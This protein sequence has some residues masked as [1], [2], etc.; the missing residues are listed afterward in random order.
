MNE[1]VVNEW[2]NVSYLTFF[3]RSNYHTSRHLTSVLPV[4]H[5][6]IYCVRQCSILVLGACSIFSS[7]FDCFL[8]CKNNTRFELSWLDSAVKDYAWRV[9]EFVC[10]ARARAGILTLA[11]SL[12][13]TLKAKKQLCWNQQ[14]VNKTSLQSLTIQTHENAWSR[15]NF[16]F[17]NQE[18]LFWIEEIYMSQDNKSF[19]KSVAII[20]D[21]T[22]EV[23][24]S[25]FLQSRIVVS[26]RSRIE[27]W[28][29]Q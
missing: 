13:L 25:S 22:W 23:L 12:T 4:L 6:F 8:S 2:M 17:F 20:E 16:F 19:F 21:V 14:K 15:N 7:K 11:L 9:R 18:C 27:H 1:V 24:F 3:V 10:L 26:H 28:R 29:T 5:A